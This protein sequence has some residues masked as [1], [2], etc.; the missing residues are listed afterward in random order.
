MI[1]CLRVIVLTIVSVVLMAGCDV[2][3][4]DVYNIEPPVHHYHPAPSNQHGKWESVHHHSRDLHGKQA[5]K[6]IKQSDVHGKVNNTHGRQVTVPSS[7]HRLHK[8]V[9]TQFNSVN[10]QTNIH[11]K[12]QAQVSGEAKLKHSRKHTNKKVNRQANKKIDE[13][14]SETVVVAK[15]R[16]HIHTH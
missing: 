2:I 14:T 13:Q 6:K 16:T 4:E 9:A 8:R 5:V 15:K 7:T 12:R 3:E 1:K 11:R 10:V